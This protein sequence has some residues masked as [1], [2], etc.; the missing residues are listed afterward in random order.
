META[1]DVIGLRA[2]YGSREVL[3]NL[4][5]GIPSLMT[6]VIIGGSG[7]GKTTLLKHLI[8]LLKPAMGTI[9][10]NNKD[11]TKM[12]DNALIEFKKKMGVLFQGAALLN[13]MSLGDNVALPLREHTQLKQP[14]IDII[15]RMKLDLVGLTG[16][17]GYYPAELSGGMKKR[18]G[19]ARA[20]AMDPELL[21][22]DE[23]SAGLDPVTAAGLD[24]LIIKL[25][26]TFKLTLVVVTHE[27]ASIFT[28]ADYVIMLDAGD[29]VFTG[30]IDE[31]RASS[32]P[33]VQAFLQR[34][35][36]EEPYRPED[37]FKIIAGS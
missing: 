8:G 35:A 28:I 25:H 24:E 19:I 36:E 9:N 33:K 12:D 20:M 30:S 3:R 22:F 23:P 5:F 10:I 26:S 7:C 11:I 15:V 1:I 29:I 2:Y 18:A 4:T 31:L 21:F 14:I 27:L 32:N 6:T 17:G 34:R 13:S 37:Y 16:F